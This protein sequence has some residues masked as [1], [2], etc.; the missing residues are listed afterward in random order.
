MY[1]NTQILRFSPVQSFNNKRR[2]WYDVH[3]YRL[4]KS[5]SDFLRCSIQ[6]FTKPVPSCRLDGI[7][8]GRSEENLS[9]LQAIKAHNFYLDGFVS[10]R[11]G[12]FLPWQC[13]SPKWE[14]V[15]HMG[16]GVRKISS[17]G[18]IIRLLRFGN[19]RVSRTNNQPR[20]KE[21]KMDHG[22]ELPISRVVSSTRKNRFH[23]S[24]L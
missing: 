19:S 15:R 14:T 2:F 3:S 16:F 8:H 22:D 4:V 12:V 20:K 6:A 23:C 24:F 17:S 10:S 18:I 11:S 9:L 21:S 13:V 7:S 1:S 5:Y